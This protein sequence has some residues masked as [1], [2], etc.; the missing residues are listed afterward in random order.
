MPTP[1]SDT[2]PSPPRV[3][4]RLGAT[5]SLVC[6]IHCAVLP[7][8]L[9][10]VPSLGIAAWF[11]D[12]FEQGFAMFATALGVTTMVWGYRRHRD[13][14]ALRL[15]LAGLAILWFGVLFEALDDMPFV[16][17]LVMATG[18]GLVGLAHLAN[19]RM[20]HGRHVHGPSCA[21]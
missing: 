4:D 2:P 12:N 7:V 21:H 10:L 13:V 16:H 15:L 18:G 14:R 11:G 1:L 17:G 20:H 6:A 3:L 19:L 8:L 5:G 9:A